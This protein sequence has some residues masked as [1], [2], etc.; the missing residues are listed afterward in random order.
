[1]ITTTTRGRLGAAG[2]IA[3][4]LRRLASRLERRRVLLVHLAPADLDRRELRIIAEA[5]ANEA[6]RQIARLLEARRVVQASRE[7]ATS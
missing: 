5:V 2:Q 1:M 3:R 6:D 7:R 4:W